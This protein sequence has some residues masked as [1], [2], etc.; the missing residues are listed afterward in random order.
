MSLGAISSERR[1][2]LELKTVDWKSRGPLYPTVNN[3]STF[4]TVQTRRV[5]KKTQGVSCYPPYSTCTCDDTVLY[6]RWN[7]LVQGHNVSSLKYVS[8]CRFKMLN[9][10]KG[11]HPPESDK[12]DTGK[13]QRYMLQSSAVL[14]KNRTQINNTETLTKLGWKGR[15]GMRWVKRSVTSRFNRIERILSS[16]L[17]LPSERTQ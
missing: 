10:P 7:L 1:A 8:N 2:K 6:D 14:D 11:M 3:I 12:V 5:L 15:A 4:P 16:Q 13:T 17:R 9:L